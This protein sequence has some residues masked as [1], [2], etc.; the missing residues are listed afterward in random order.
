MEK[1]RQEW[2]QCGLKL[3]RLVYWNVDARSNTILDSGD[4]VSFVSGFSPVIFQQIIKGVTGVELMLQTLQSD[5]YK[6]IV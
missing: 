6:D 3:P 5:R 1:I 4:L 2:A